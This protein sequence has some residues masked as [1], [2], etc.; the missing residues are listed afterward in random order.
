[1]SATRPIVRGARRASAPLRHIGVIGLLL[2]VPVIALITLWPTHFLL[3]FKPRVVRGIEWLHDREMFEWIYWTRLEVLANV[4]MFVPLALLLTFVLGARR[5]WVALALCLALTV[6]IE[7]IQH[8]MPGRVAS[9]KDVVANGTGAA[10][11]VLLAALTERTLRFE[12]RV[13]ANPL[14]LRRRSE[15]PG[16][17]SGGNPRPH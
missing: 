7:A 9:L 16:V 13:A 1:M 17:S 3:R 10:I 2:A 15:E 14:G 12:R 4:A 8:F 5:W 6:G 11:G